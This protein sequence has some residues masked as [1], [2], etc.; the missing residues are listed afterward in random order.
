MESMQDNYEIKKSN[1]CTS[2]IFLLSG[3]SNN[4]AN[5]SNTKEDA[6]HKAIEDTIN[7]PID[8]LQDY[9]EFNEINM[10]DSLKPNN[11]VVKVGD[12]IQFVYQCLN[13]YNN[14]RLNPRGYKKEFEDTHQ[15]EDLALRNGE[16]IQLSG[17]T[18]NLLL[19]TSLSLA[20]NVKSYFD[21]EVYSNYSRLTTGMEVNSDR[22]S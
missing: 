8:S 5:R 17:K 18:D 11:E 14:S 3:F 19:K 7:K 9:A 15:K 1:Y 21:G 12:S 22:C 2:Y 10:P 20:L 4:L 13:S 16:I 6:I